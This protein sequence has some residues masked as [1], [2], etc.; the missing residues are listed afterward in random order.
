LKDLASPEKNQP[1]PKLAIKFANIVFVS[2]VFICLV[3]ILY[4]IYRLYVPYYDF[5][6]GD[7]GYQKTYYVY[8]LI[9]TICGILF[10]FCLW[11]KENIKVNLSLVVVTFLISLYSFEFYIEFSPITL[12]EKARELGVPFDSREPFEVIRDLRNEGIDISPNVLPRHWVKTNGLESNSG[13]IYPL[14]GIPNI[15]TI[16]INEGGFFPVIK[17]DEH[18]F[19]NPKGLYDRSEVDIVLIGD[20]FTEG[21]SVQANENIS[22]VL[23]KMGFNIINLGKAGNGPLMELATPKDYAET[24]K[25]EVVLWLF[26]MNDINDLLFD[27]Q[28]SLL[29]RYANEAD[30]SQKLFSQ[31]K[32]VT[33]TLME[34]AD[35]N[36]KEKESYQDKSPVNDSSYSL[37]NV[38]KLYNLRMLIY[39]KTLEF[40]PGSKI[41]FPDPIFEKIMKKGK[42]LVNSWGGELYHVF[43]PSFGIDQYKYEQALRQYFLR[44]MSELE[45]PIID[46]YQEVFAAHADPM[47]LAPLRMSYHYNAEGYRLMAEAIARN[48]IKDGFAPSSPE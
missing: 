39:P 23:R 9:F 43:L 26:F 1:I 14:G 34:F 28:S 2:G 13:R 38:L 8:I 33:R 7:K 32:E 10:G 45:N 21:V 46:G 17:L 11:L 18:G 36:W 12:E 25:P 30:F 35:Q 44:F 47:S 15:S 31:Q 22:S 16:Y 37:I 4:S 3:A 40:A 24:I 29:M 42:K 5:N 48:L 6:Y 41:N 27:T 20:S 19:N